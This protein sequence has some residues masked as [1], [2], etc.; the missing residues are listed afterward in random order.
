MQKLRK[1]DVKN[2]NR[3]DYVAKA[4]RLCKDTA[5]QPLFVKR[6]A[7]KVWDSDPDAGI[8]SSESK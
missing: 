8:F 1:I 6:V 4:V 5:V 3:V 7:G 2:Y